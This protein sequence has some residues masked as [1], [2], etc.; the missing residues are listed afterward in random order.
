VTVPASER[1]CQGLEAA[2]GKGSTQ[3][4]DR[5]QQSFC[6]SL[7]PEVHLQ[8]AAASLRSP[9]PSDTLPSAEMRYLL[10]A[11]AFYRKTASKTSEA[12]IVDNSEPPYSRTCRL[13]ALAIRVASG[14]ISISQEGG[15]NAELSVCR[16]LYVQF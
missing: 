7:G 2:L 15:S 3:G 13:Q 10:G 4:L 5:D 16:T 14:L 1:G 11:I 6:Q 12:A 9:E 8:R